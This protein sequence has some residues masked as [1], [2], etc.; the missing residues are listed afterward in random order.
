MNK[1]TRHA[2]KDK[3]LSIELKEF[4]RWLNRQTNKTLYRKYRVRK[5]LKQGYK[6]QIMKKLK[7]ILKTYIGKLPSQLTNADII[8][9]EDRCY[10]QYENNGNLSR[11]GA[12]NK[13]LIYLGHEDWKL[14]LPYIEKKTY[15]TLTEEERTNYLNAANS[16][17]EGL[18]I[19]NP[20]SLRPK[21]K[22]ML[23]DRAIVIMQ[24][25]LISR[26]SELC[27]IETKNLRFERNRIVLRDSK[28]HEDI[29]RRGMEDAY[30]TTPLAEQAIRDWLKVRE[31]LTAN[32]P[33]DEKYLF[34]HPS[35][36]YSGGK[37]GYNKI[38][39]TCK[40]IGIKAGIT[41]IRT[42]PY[43]LKRSEITRD[44]DRTENVRI[45]QI[46]A[47]H[48]TYKSTMRYNNKGS[49]DVEDY[50]NSEKYNDTSI[51][52][53]KKIQKLAEKAASGEIP[54]DVYQRLRADLLIEQPEFKKVNN[55]IGY[56]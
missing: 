15:D 47:R 16:L 25:T 36:R 20:L 18:N 8:E 44:C 52:V 12:M 13:L 34:I 40:E 23:L 3:E 41:S 22:T 51:S 56:D 11:F 28:T 50:I 10:K 29:I 39:R 5:P 9:W 43:C 53:K 30:I 48:T 7:S 21:Q 33:N 4:E 32:N 6:R 46:R 38:L 49:R 55:L 26:P 14:K 2:I 31:T 27:N 42:N 54:I 17:C 19:G 1:T 24:A 45:P 35:G 37:I